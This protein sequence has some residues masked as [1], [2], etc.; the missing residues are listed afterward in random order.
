MVFQLMTVLRHGS[1]DEIIARARQKNPEITVST[2]Y[3]I[4]DAF[5]EAGLLSKIR[6]PDGKYYY[7]ITMAAHHHVF[8]DNEMIDY[9]D[10]SL[11]ELIRKRLKGDL[12]KHLNIEKISVQIVVSCQR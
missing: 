10:P 3:R 4:L 12:F 7:D 8:I 6:H 11:T 1:I 9:I 2:V 5:F